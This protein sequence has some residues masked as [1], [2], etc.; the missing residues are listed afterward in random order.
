M[1]HTVDFLENPA[2]RITRRLLTFSLACWLTT[3]PGDI[4]LRAATAAP[5][6]SNAFDRHRMLAHLAR[7]VMLPTYVRFE[8]AAATLHEAAQALC[9]ERTLSHLE[10]TQQAWRQA[11]ILWKRT[12]AFQLGPTHTFVAAIDYWPARPH[13]LQRA[14]QASASMTLARV[15]SLGA[16]AKGLPALEY[17]LFDPQSDAAAVLER[18]REGPPAASRCAYLVA[19]TAHLAQQAQFVV[20]LWRPEGLDF[21]GEVARAG[22]G[23]A[24]YRSVHQAISALVN[25]LLQAVETL[26][27]KKIA[28]PLRGNGRTPWPQAAEAWRSGYSVAHM[29]GSLAGAFHL[30]S[31]AGNTPDRIGF[32]DYLTALGSPLGRNI[33]QHFESALE[34]VRAIPSPLHV[35]VVDQPEK[36]N[37]AYEAVH[38]LLILLKVDMTNLLGVTVDFSDNDGD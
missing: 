10:A 20:Q 25:H 5:S 30:Y 27:N 31:G 7:Q 8:R 9:A 24:T 34:A 4:C 21:V 12:E 16:R 1:R 17:L 11:A 35:A 37:V 2:L 23:S 15:E 28:K 36:V 18:F 33:T 19:L 14:L 29:V 32:D 22:R 6:P 13:L 38:A 3:L 26:Q